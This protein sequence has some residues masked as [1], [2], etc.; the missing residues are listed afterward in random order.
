MLWPAAAHAQH[1]DGMRAS[2]ARCCASTSPDST[3]SRDSDPSAWPVASARPSGRQTS[4][5]IREAGADAHSG[6]QSMRC[7]CRDPSRDSAAAT[8]MVGLHKT[9]ASSALNASSWVSKNAC[10]CVSPPS[11]SGQ[12]NWLSP[13]LSYTTT[14]TDKTVVC[15]S[16]LLVHVPANCTRTCSG[17]RYILQSSAATWRSRCTSSLRMQP[18]C[19]R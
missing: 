16:L 14:P 18:R 17:C 12:E 6:D 4:A 7:S 1:R 13:I 3:S 8:S 2:G 5:V 11:I 15:T 9:A 19:R 10:G